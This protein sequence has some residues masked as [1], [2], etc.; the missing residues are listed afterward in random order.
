MD[1][2]IRELEYL[3]EICRKY[4]GHYLNKYFGFT[5]K[6]I[7]ENVGMHRTL[8]LNVIRERDV[9]PKKWKVRFVEVFNEMKIRER[10]ENYRETSSQLWKKE[11]NRKMENLLTV[12]VIGIIITTMKI[13]TSSFLNAEKLT[14]RQYITEC[15]GDLARFSDGI[16]Y[17]GFAF[18]ARLPYFFCTSI[19]HFFNINR[20]GNSMRFFCF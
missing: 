7:A 16:T 14:C 3:K 2:T 18:F 1:D 13:N 10:T 6:E 8:L 19:A 15:R 9:M 17:G 12:L 20:M 4:D 11:M 5:L